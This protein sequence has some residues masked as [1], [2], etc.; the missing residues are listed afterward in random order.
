M[1]TYTYIL[2]IAMLL[3]MVVFTSCKKDDDD[4][5]KTSRLATYEYTHS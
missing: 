4:D 3:G 5:D 2:S 1:K